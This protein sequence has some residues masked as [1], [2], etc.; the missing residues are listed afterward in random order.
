MRYGVIIA[1][2]TGSSRLPGK[3]LLPLKG[4]PMIVFLIR[5]LRFSRLADQ[6]VF[7][8][9]TLAE[10]DRL[11]EVVASEGIPVFRG[12]NEDVVKR[13]VNTAD[14]FE[15]EYG[16]RVTGD[17]PFVDGETLDYCLKKCEE[18]DS[19]D[20]ASTKKAFPVGIDYEIYAAEVIKKLHQSDKLNAEGREHLT[21]YIYD[22]TSVFDVRRIYPPEKWNCHKSAFTVDTAEDYR[23]AQQV[24]EQFDTVHFSVEELIKSV[25]A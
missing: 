14:E 13:F 2:R 22:H 10:D 23:F 16:V 4:I 11:V 17:C 1:A 18:F 9:T 19:F 8:T 12:A 6:I 25:R 3:V 5:R 7:A 21:K 15:I 20:L 24:L